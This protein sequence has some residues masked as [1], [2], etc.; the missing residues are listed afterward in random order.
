VQ[1][2]LPGQFLA[3]DIF[4]QEVEN[5]KE[6]NLAKFETFQPWIAV[7]DRLVI[8]Q[9]Q[10][11][12]IIK[13]F[14]FAVCVETKDAVSPFIREVVAKIPE[15]VPFLLPAVELCNL[16][17]MTGMEFDRNFPGDD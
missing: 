5:A 15:E 8:P 10:V 4:A 16:Q 9:V 17:Q 6:I 2:S 14:L 13:G 1:D 11:A 7:L 3:F 12:R